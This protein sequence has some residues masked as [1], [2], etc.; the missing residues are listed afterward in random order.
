M[1]NTMVLVIAFF[2]CLRLVL[3]I[4]FSPAY[5]WQTNRFIQHLTHGGK[6][7]ST[8]SR[9]K[10]NN[11]QQACGVKKTTQETH[12]SYQTYNAP[13][14]AADENLYVLCISCVDF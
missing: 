9:T 11:K 5:N 4:A 14:D 6:V 3:V 2:P 10:N 1:R 13:T 7:V 8:F 12:P